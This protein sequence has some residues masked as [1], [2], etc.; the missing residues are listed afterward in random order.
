MKSVVEIGAFH[1]YQ[2]ALFVDNTPWLVNIAS[3]TAS[4]FRMTRV[5]PLLGRYLTEED[6]REGAADVLV[7]GH[8][9]WRDR[10]Q[11]DRSEWLK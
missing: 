3:M 4:A 2:T 9:A 6:E 1:E 8:D 11:Q 7:I 5:A 10:F